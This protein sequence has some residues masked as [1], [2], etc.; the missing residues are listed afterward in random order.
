M[1]A[2]V[3]P[4]TPIK[5]VEEVR[6]TCGS[7]HSYNHCPLTRSGNEFS[8]FH[9]NIQQFQAAAVG[10]FI[11]GNRHSN[12]SSQMRPPGFNQPNNQ[13]NQNRYQGN[14]FNPNHNQ[15]CQNNQEVV[16]QNPQQQAST[17]QAPV[18]QNSNN[19]FEAY[20]KANDANINTS[21]ISP[22]YAIASILSTKVPEHSPSMGYE[23]LSTT[24]EME[25]DEV[26]ESSAKNLLPIPSEYEVTS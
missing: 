21:Q 6:V 26:I 23:H 7:N 4:T 18:L 8:I 5:V 20:T 11:Q 3:T 9:D 15:N 16:F 12:F 25:S 14:N 1:K 19:K 13:N 10:N 24:P 2:F 17:Y 22:V